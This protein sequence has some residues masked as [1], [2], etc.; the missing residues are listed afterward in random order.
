MRSIET[1]RRTEEITNVWFDEETDN[2]ETIVEPEWIDEGKFAN[3]FIIFKDKNTG[4]FYRLSATRSGSY[5]T[6]YDID[7]DDE[8]YEV[9]QVEKLVKVWEEVV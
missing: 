9:H 6:D 7:F 2:Y 8:C 3:G 1:M 5:Y 4:K